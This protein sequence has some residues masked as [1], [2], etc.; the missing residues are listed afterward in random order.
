[1]YKTH[2]VINVDSKERALGES[3]SDFTLHLGSQI[4]LKEG[5][6]YF[7]RPENIKIATSFYNINLTNNVL[8]IDEFNGATTFNLSITIP[9]GNYTISELM[10]DVQTLLNT[11]TGQANTYTLLYDVKTGLVNIAFTGG[12]TD[13]TVLTTGGIAKILG[14]SVQ[15]VITTNGSGD[16][17]AATHTIRYINIFSSLPVSNYYSAQGLQKVIGKVPIIE[18]RYQF[19]FFPNDQ[20]YLTQINSESFHDIQT[21]LRDGDNRQMQMNGI[22]FSYDL[23]IYTIRESFNKKAISKFKQIFQR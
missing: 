6:K 21:V 23:V 5:R 9:Q 14:F 22:D 16:I 12:S 13:I 18:T 20:G 3:I 4:R 11:N 2:A 7:V 15:Q 17:L 10:V 1:M 8:N 19:N